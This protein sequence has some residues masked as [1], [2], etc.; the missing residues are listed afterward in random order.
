MVHRVRFTNVRNGVY[1]YFYQLIDSVKYN[2][3]HYTHNLRGIEDVLYTNHRWPPSSRR[4]ALYPTEDLGGS[5]QLLRKTIR[6]H[7]A[8]VST[9]YLYNNGNSGW[10]YNG[11]IF[12]GYTERG[13]TTSDLPSVTP[14]IFWSAFGAKGWEKY[15]PNR[16]QRSLSQ[17]LG[18]MRDLASL[19]PSING[20]KEVIRDFRHLMTFTHGSSRRVHTLNL[21]PLSGRTDLPIPKVPKDVS[22]AYLMYEFGWK[23]MLKDLSDALT[24]TSEIEDA[25]RQLLR[26]NDRPIRRG[27]T[28]SKDFSDESVTT[29]GY[30]STPSL[31]SYL[32]K[33]TET[34]TVE[35]L[36]KK[37]YKFSGRFRYHIPLGNALPDIRKRREQLA[38]MIYGAELTP[39]LLWELQPWTWLAD[40]FTS[41]GAIISNLS[42]DRDNLVADYAYLTCHT[43][44]LV[45]KTVSGTL[46]EWGPYTAT[47]DLVTEVKE[48]YAASPYGFGIAWNGFSPRQYAILAALGMSRSF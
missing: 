34:Q 38:R 12:A 7:P 9:R 6:V 28:V 26:D 40:W 17:A 21:N 46:S 11:E 33:E 42:D 39:S 47:E 18:E 23:P 44:G 30:F 36:Y 37:H 32:Y 13:Y 2:E 43:V 45:R 3:A 19:F 41:L 14:A 31:P 1:G 48:R 8:N 16:P 5:F 15:K 35:T 20:L 22:D 25:L 24:K 29:K 27:G 10:V 4:K